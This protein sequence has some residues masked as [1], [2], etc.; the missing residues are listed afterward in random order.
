M[1]NSLR[2][3]K[4]STKNKTKDKDKM[5]QVSSTILADSKQQNGRKNEMYQLL[6]TETEEESNFIRNEHMDD[7]RDSSDELV[8]YNNSNIRTVK[9]LDEINQPINTSDNE[10][11]LTMRSNEEGDEFDETIN[12]KK[13]S[14]EQESF[15]TITLQVFF[16]FLLAG[17]GMVGAGLVLDKVQHWEVF[18]TVR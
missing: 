9:D 18:L 3:R 14:T 8:V 16:P 15:L 2:L 17:F 11:L 1:F 10:P 5:G 12:I 7:D 13:S 6:P 4:F